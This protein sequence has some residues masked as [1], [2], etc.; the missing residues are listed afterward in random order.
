MI[1][2]LDIARRLAALALMAGLTG[3]APRV[4]IIALDKKLDGKSLG[5]SFS[6]EEADKRMPYS[7]QFANPQGRPYQDDHG[8]WPL[9][10]VRRMDNTYMLP[11][12]LK[13]VWSSGPVAPHWMPW[14]EGYPEAPGAQ[15]RPMDPASAAYDLATRFGKPIEREVLAYDP[16]L[17]GGQAAV[18]AVW[19][20]G[21]WVP[22]YY[23]RTD[24][25]LGRRIHFNYGLKPDM[26]WGDFMLNWPEVSLTV[27]RTQ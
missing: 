20:D 4:N 19:L 24:E 11:L 5:A 13:L 16:V 26:T 21:E 23:T 12:P 17:P 7:Y 8:V 9:T 10:A 2:A 25:L 1:N 18:F 14:Q 27:R 3:C 22:C 15:L 6:T